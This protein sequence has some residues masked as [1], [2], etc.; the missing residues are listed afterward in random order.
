MPAFAAREHDTGSIDIGRAADTAKFARNNQG[1]WILTARYTQQPSP[2][3]RARTN[4]HT[5]TQHNFS[6]L[7][8]NVKE[9]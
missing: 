7:E 4:T 3:T 1:V 5:H 2:Y 9:K 6:F 8:L